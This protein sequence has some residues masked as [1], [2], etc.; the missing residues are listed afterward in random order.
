MANVHE[1]AVL[2]TVDPA[3][4]LRHSSTRNT[5]ELT[6]ERFFEEIKHFGLQTYPLPCGTSV[7]HYWHNREKNETYYRFVEQLLQRLEGFQNTER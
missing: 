7:F 1:A 4:L 2:T 6:A 3:G 5:L